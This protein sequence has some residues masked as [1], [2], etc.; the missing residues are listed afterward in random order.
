VI[1]SAALDVSR[2]L[3]SSRTANASLVDG[4]VGPGKSETTQD[5]RAENRLNYFMFVFQ[6]QMD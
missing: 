6:L 5:N 4:L 1:G 2:V 3:T